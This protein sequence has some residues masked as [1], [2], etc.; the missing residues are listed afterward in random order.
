MSTAILQDTFSQFRDALAAY[1]LNPPEIIA[2]GKIH[3]FSVSD[4]KGR[5]PAFY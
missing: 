1:D 4:D 3:R 2:D 5:I